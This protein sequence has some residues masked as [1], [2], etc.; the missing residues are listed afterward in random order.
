MALAVFEKD[1]HVS[2]RA[3]SSKNVM[4]ILYEILHF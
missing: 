2:R 3:L 4:Q 1:E